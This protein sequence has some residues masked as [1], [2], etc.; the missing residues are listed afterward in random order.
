MRLCI[1]RFSSAAAPPAMPPAGEPLLLR[2]DVPPVRAAARCELRSALRRV[3]A[4][5]SGLPPEA[6][7]LAETPHGPVWHGPCRGGVAP[8]ISLSYAGGTAWVGLL[9]GGPIGIDAVEAAAFGEMTDVA[10]LYLG[11]ETAAAVRLSADPGRAF[12]DAWAERE[13]RI[14]C[15][16]LELA[17]WS[18]ERARLE[19]ACRCL[20]EAV[21]GVVL[22]AAF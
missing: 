21:D 11:P 5:W 13:A 2:V 12:A 16:G 19:A 20:H 1:Q 14:K 22:A 18:P 15:L 7:P 8:G 3:L 6:L 10:R 17:E 4:A 9:P